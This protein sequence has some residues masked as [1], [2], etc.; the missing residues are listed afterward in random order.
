MEI[1]PVPENLVLPIRCLAMAAAAFSQAF[2]ATTRGKD[3]ADILMSDPDFWLKAE[4]AVTAWRKHF[5]LDSAG[6][7]LEADEVETDCG[8]CGCP[9]VAKA[10][11][12]MRDTAAVFA[13][14]PDCT[15]EG[16]LKAGGRVSKL[17]KEPEGAR[18]PIG[19][20]VTTPGA[21]KALA[22]ARQG[23]AE[24]IA[25]HA[26]GDWGKN[27][28]LDKTKVTARQTKEGAC[29]TDDVAKLNKIAVDGGASGR[30]ESEYQTSKGERLWVM[31]T[32][33]HRETVV[34]LPSEY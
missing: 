20:V 26:A 10:P 7:P 5:R 14:C 18:F 8:L 21:S 33:S 9:A 28:H 12:A 34:M 22:D 13:M 25:R 6:K 32:L 15:E 2:V 1:P 27:G 11:N 3:A 17:A 31:T 24:F 4:S 30:I 23:A 19:A 16:L 29:A